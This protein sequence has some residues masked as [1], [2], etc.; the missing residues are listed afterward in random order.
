MLMAA[1]ILV[2]AAYA[3]FLFRT[4]K[5][6]N[7]AQAARIVPWSPE[8]QAGIGN[9]RRA[10]ELNPYYAEGW[11][12]LAVEAEGKGEMGEAE[13][14]FLK[15]G[16]VDKRFRARWALANFYY[17]RERWEEF[18]KW[19][20]L[21]SERSYGDRTAM[22]QLAER[23]GDS[24]EVLKKGLAVDA[25]LL[26]EYLEYQLQRKQVDGAWAAG[27]ALME[28]MTEGERPKLLKRCEVLLEAERVEEGIAVWNR[29]QP[30]RRVAPQ[31]GIH[32]GNAGLAYAPLAWG[33]DWRL[34]WRDEVETRWAARRIRVELSGKQ[35]EQVE[36]ISLWVPVER[37]V[38]Y[39]FGYR[40]RTEGIGKK[41]GLRW[42]VDGAAVDGGSLWAAD[43]KDG[44]LR[45]TP[46]G[47]KRLV[48]LV[49][50][51]DRELGT[52]RAAGSLELDGAFSFASVTPSS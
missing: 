24:R 38:Q 22:F 26:G 25:A 52:M 34:L 1:A 47:G 5:P 40:Y 45:V 2:V 15:A 3:E 39:E 10:V 6:E 46:G 27:Q 30:E 51:F 13:R 37:G 31:E 19:L 18:W 43:W 42:V 33:L 41:S 9:M 11:M 7:M 17:R 28:Q 20:K 48:K 44:R 23:V 50:R 12:E 16:E 21:A 32:L 14:F 35:P 36:L 4:G 8:Y 49:L 29:L